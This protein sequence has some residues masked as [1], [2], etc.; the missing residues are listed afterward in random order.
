VW[1]DGMIDLD[2]GSTGLIPTQKSYLSQVKVQESRLVQEVGTNQEVETQV[3]IHF[4][5]IE[6]DLIL[7]IQVQEW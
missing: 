7:V 6:C 2:L 1:K 5:T 3:Y 4:P